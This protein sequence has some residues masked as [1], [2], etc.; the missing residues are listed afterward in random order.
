MADA[1]IVVPKHDF[2]RCSI[3]HEKIGHECTLLP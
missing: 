1:G 3:D 2:T